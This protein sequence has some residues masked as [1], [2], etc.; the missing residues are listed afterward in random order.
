MISLVLTSRPVAIWTCGYD[1][2]VA[3]LCRQQ[4]GQKHLMVLPIDPE[5]PREKTLDPRTVFDS[6][7]TLDVDFRLSPSWFRYLRTTEARFLQIVSRT[8]FERTVARV[9]HRMKEVGADRLIVFGGHLAAIAHA[10]KARQVLFDVCDSYS[11]TIRRQIEHGSGDRAWRERASKRLALHRWQRAEALLPH[12]FP[13]VTTINDAD[14][15]EVARLAG[16]ASNVHTVPNGVGESFLGPLLPA[17]TRRG[18]A[19]WGNLGF[20]PNAAALRHLVDR[21]YQPYLRERGVELCL[22]GNG[23]PG[24]LKERAAHDPQLRLVGFVEDLGRTVREYPAM[25][26][27]ML[28][29]SGM[30]NK[31]LEAFGLGLVVVSTSLG[32]ESVPL[33]RHGSHHLAADEPQAFAQHV[34]RVLDDPQGVEPIR[35]GAHRL[36]HEHYRWDVIGERWRA[37]LDALD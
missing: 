25:V 14:S 2:R 12:W 1:L 20:A 16:G 27:P 10:T 31:V 26:N 9:G 22:V 15:A 19:F 17:G 7:E 6:V 4:H 21:I 30:K 3:N 33:A 32:I 18:V 37:L 36:L 13:A 23:A 8:A 5:D 29:G 28:I 35:A 34:L 24:W 11:L